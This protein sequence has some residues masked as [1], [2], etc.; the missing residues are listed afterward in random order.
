MNWKALTRVAV[1]GLL[2]WT[3][4]YGNP[5]PQSSAGAQP[6]KVAAVDFVPAWGDLDGNIRR[7]VEAAKEASRQGVALA[8]FP[9]TALSGYLFSDPAQIAPFLDTIPGKTTAALLPVLARAGM[10]MSVGIAERDAETGIAYNS[11]VLLGPK[12][13]IGKYRKNGLN[14]QDQKVFAPGDTGVEVFDTPIGRIALTICYDNTYWQYARLAALRG[15]QII[16]WNSVSDRVMPGTP[17]AEAKGDHSTVANVQY[18]SAQNGVFV[19]GAT[20]SGIETNPITGGK[21]YYN[22]GSSI[23][24][25]E[26]RKLAQAPVV[27]PEDLAPGLNGVITATIRPADADR[28]RAARLALRRPALYLPLLALHRSPVD[29]NA[30]ATPRSVSLAA[31]QWPEGPSRLAAVTPVEGELMVLPELSGLASGIGADEIKARAETAGGAF[32]KTLAAA[33]QAGKG[34]LVGSYPERDGEKVFH[35]VV[36]AGPE[37][38]I[39][40]RYRV[41]HPSAAQ[42]A[43]ATPGD[44]ITV[45]ETPLGRIGLASAGELSVPELGGLYAAL[46]TDILAAPAGSPEPL[47]VEIDP[48]LYSVANPPTDRADFF[49]YAAAKLNQFWLVSGGRR[50]GDHTAA[51]IYGPDPVV[52]T[53]TLIASA[54]APAVHYRTILPAPGTWINQAQLIDGQQAQWFPPLVL[55]DGNACLERWRRQSAGLAPCR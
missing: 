20:R 11:A 16:A 12:G 27:P 6:I 28:S 5:M 47:K 53:P 38:V 42:A 34:Y 10:Y 40:G 17:P 21:L 26:G 15:A 18:M 19:I 30:T 31:A 51:A 37:G 23:W 1:L 45:A 3:R 9:E 41:T 22:G 36:L 35:T 44:Q 48:A 52:S 4:A 8:V 32:E 33:A 39:L 49:P 43:W 50:S 7:L 25:P 55:Q 14:P 24:S 2:A 29:G 13:I 54:G 46:R